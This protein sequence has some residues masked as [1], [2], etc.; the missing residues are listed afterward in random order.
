MG[1][2]EFIGIPLTDLKV[3][4]L[5][6]GCATFGWTADETESHQV[7]DAFWG[8]GGNS[9]DTADMYAD[10][11]SESIIRNWM[12]SKGN[13]RDMVIATKVGNKPN[14]LGLS[15]ENIL[16][17]C[18]ESLA[19]LKTDYIDIYFAH[20]DDLSVEPSESLRAFGQL[21]NDGRVRYIGASNFSSER[22]SKSL[23]SSEFSYVMVQDKYNL[24]ERFDYENKLR[25]TV[26]NHG[27]SNLPYFSLAKGFLTGKYRRRTDKSVWEAAHGSIG[28]SE[29]N[30]KKYLKVLDGVTKISMDVGCSVSAIALAW[31]RRQPSVSI[32]IAS[33]RTVNQMNQI[34]EVIKL[35]EL[36]SAMLTA[37]TIDLHH[38]DDPLLRGIFRR[39]SSK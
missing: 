8:M 6:L 19:R 3:Y 16:R 35:S 29:Y 26:L 10:G 13:R 18:D 5:M 22:L 14:R 39:L 28:V 1:Q 33:A 24:V 7:L 4:P 15:Y 23:K 36:Q 2:V 38:Q 17:A 27:L 25:N 34:G 31:L 9:L 30:Q 11:I 12:E 20:D 37:L 21:I 32:P